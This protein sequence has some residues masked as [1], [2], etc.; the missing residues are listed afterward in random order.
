[1]IKGK[2]MRI[3]MMSVCTVLMM[4][5]CADK[6]AFDMFKMDKVYER[7]V[8]QT[9][10]GSIVRSLETKALVS[11]VYLDPIYPE[12]YNDGEYFVGA[13][14]FE[15]DNRDVK[16]WDLA[17]HGYTLTLNG[18]TPTL[19]EELKESD[20]RRSFIPVQNNWNK[21]YFIRFDSQSEGALVLLLDNNQTG[22]VA[23]TYQKGK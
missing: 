3:L 19:I 7:A 20:P 5:G 15:R 11:A 16:K 23:L 12:Q 9:R 17:T 13:V 21:Y 22:Q 6:G 4:S 2:K 14:Y 1:M 18:K 10:T 8:E